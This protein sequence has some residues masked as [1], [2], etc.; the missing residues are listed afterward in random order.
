MAVSVTDA[1]AI[2][3]SPPG[4]DPELERLEIELLLEAVFRRYGFDFRSY[5]YA[6]VRRR[7]WRRVETDGLPS[8]SALQERVLHD[9][10]AMEQLLMD[11]S[12]N[13]TA[14]FRDPTFYQT[15]REVVVP[16]LRTYPFIRI[17]H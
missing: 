6:S 2:P 15:F 3:T 4:Y 14:M 13:V 10:S 17:W 8:I 9:T 5:A 16:V 7:L 11:L 1:S 12:I